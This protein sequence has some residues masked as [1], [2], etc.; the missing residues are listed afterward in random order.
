M[1]DIFVYVPSAEQIVRIAEGSGDNLDSEDFDA[2]YVDYIYY[3]QHSLDVGMP[4]IDGGM[5]LKKDMLTDIYGTLVEAVKEV[6]E[7]A[8]GTVPEYKVLGEYGS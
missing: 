8:F 1:E 3:E 4:E 6:L 7:M 2:G 5:I